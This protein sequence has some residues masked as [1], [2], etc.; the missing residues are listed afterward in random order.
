[1]KRKL[2]SKLLPT[3]L[4]TQV[5][6]SHAQAQIEI[7][8]AGPRYTS[9]ILAS[10]LK[11]DK[12]QE[13]T[14]EES[15]E[16]TQLEL[17]PDNKDSKV[18]YYLPPVVVSTWKQQP[19]SIN[20]MVQERILKAF[21][22]LVDANISQMKTLVSAVT[23]GRDDKSLK[24]TIPELTKAFELINKDLKDQFVS[25][26]SVIQALLPAP[27][28]ALAITSAE[29][30]FLLGS[31]I[32]NDLPSFRAQLNLAL[33]YS[34]VRASALDKLK[35]LNPELKFITI[36]PVADFVLRPLKRT[37]S[38]ASPTDDASRTAQSD[39]SA[40]V[41][42]ED[43]LYSSL[44]GTRVKTAGG[45]IGMD[46]F[47]N[48][49]RSWNMS[50]DD[51][52]LG[53]GEMLIEG[54]WATSFPMSVKF[55]GSLKC[56]YR[57]DIVFKKMFSVEQIPDTVLLVDTS[58]D[59]ENLQQQNVMCEIY[60]KSGNLLSNNGVI[61]RG[62]IDLSAL[63]EGV[64]LD[65][66]VKALNG[67]I[68]DKITR[69]SEE[70]GKSFKAAASIV[71]ALQTRASAEVDGYLNINVPMTTAYREKWET[72]PLCREFPRTTDNCI[73]HGWKKGHKIKSL[74]D[75]WVCK[76]YE[77]ITEKECSDVQRARW[78]AY[79]VPVKLKGFQKS[80]AFEK[81]FNDEK[82]YIIS[83]QEPMF[84]T[85]T[86]K[87][88][89]CFQR[90]PLQTP[91]PGKIAEFTNCNGASEIDAQRRSVNDLPEINSKPQEAEISGI[92]YY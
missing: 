56:N 25:S 20:L 29:E 30:A 27:Y 67:Q 76:E 51:P 46:L 18:Y 12:W 44:I 83:A 81:R 54:E 92:V 71:E 22:L 6:S 13:F 36:N 66:M 35:K 9:A 15:Q 53:A 89:A 59:A 82:T 43:K 21:L 62:A 68:Q 31:A 84:V 32:L 75:K 63:P 8:T 50:A 64:T 57:A 47:Y 5:I 41:K 33:G 70:N 17:Y 90:I 28:T 39:Y 26:M 79:Q 74:G 16:I 73:R 7:T 87:N 72:Y 85:V 10:A 65:Q 58:T 45:V 48:T 14:Q 49:A 78:E 38:I 4:C 88:D 91:S 11:G 55:D 40:K 34:K 69:F 52:S 61:E 86:T 60:D 80:V 19:Y 23:E 3:I 2:F 77:V 37:G 1:M 24:E 42:F